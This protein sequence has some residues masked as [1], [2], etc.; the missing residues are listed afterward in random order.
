MIQLSQR[1][2]CATGMG[3]GGTILWLL[4]NMQKKRKLWDDASRKKVQSEFWD[5]NL[6]FQTLEC[7]AVI[8]I[9]GYL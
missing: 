2:V 6:K 7:K 8:Y 3:K 9:W 4:F 5:A 1:R